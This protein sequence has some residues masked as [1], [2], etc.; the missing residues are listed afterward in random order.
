MSADAFAVYRDQLLQQAD[1]AGW[2][3]VIHEDMGCIRGA[4]GWA[5]AIELAT[6]DELVR[7]SRSLREHAA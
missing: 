3:E 6:G 5:A 4:A 1:A 7:L 2:P